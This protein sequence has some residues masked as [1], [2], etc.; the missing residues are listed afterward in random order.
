MTSCPEIGS[1]F[2]NKRV[3]VAGGTGM[4]GIQLVTLLIE[5]G[6]IIRIASMDDSSLA[7]TNTDEF[8]RSDLRIYS[9]CLKVCEEMDMVFNLLGVKGSPSTAKK[10]PATSFYNNLML[11]VQLIQAA[12]QCNVP[13]FLY[14]STNGVYAPTSLMKEGEMWNN[15]PSSH[16]KGPAWAKRMGEL[17]SELCQTEH[18]TQFTIV[19]PSNIY[20]P[21]DNFD[22]EN[23]MVI[24]SLIKKAVISSE[25]GVPM[26]I[27]GDGS[28]KRD[29]IHAY[30]VAMAMMLAI[31]K[32][33]GQVL[34]ISSGVGTS[35]Q[36]LVATILKQI[37]HR[38]HFREQIEVKWDTSKP[39]GDQ[40][41]VLDNTRLNSLGFKERIPLEKGIGETISW[42]LANRKNPPKRFNALE[43]TQN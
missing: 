40:E 16:D 43:K 14:T 35:I 7:P 34:N 25:T 15:P 31:E 4:V 32:A 28:P 42:F 41:R 24:P 18:Q 20:G 19:R 11:S 5:Q 36:T 30:D 9:N 29:F 6:A 1:A 21:Y 2:K 8:V 27:W 17:F 38:R 26:E 22:S 23:A 10:Y 3:L 33:P 37:Q 12:C 13:R 39:S